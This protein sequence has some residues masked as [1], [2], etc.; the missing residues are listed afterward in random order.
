MKSSDLKTKNSDELNSLLLVFKKELF[1]LR[2][3]RSNGTLTNKARF[4]IVKKTIARIY[5]FIN[6]VSSFVGGK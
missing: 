1:N 4:S 6:N 2:F 5:T 3:Q